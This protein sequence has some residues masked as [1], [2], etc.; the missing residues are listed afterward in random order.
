MAQMQPDG[1]QLRIIPWAF[2]PLV[3]MFLFAIP[4]KTKRGCSIPPR[5]IFLYN[6]KIHH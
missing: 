4:E 6:E 5:A 1:E 3:N 2:F